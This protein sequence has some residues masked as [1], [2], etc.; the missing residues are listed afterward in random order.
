[1]AENGGVIGIHFCSRLVLG[2][3]GIQSEIEDV[4]KQIEAVTQIGGIEVVGLG[5]DYMLNFE[6]RDEDYLRNTNQLDISWTKGLEDTSEIYNIVEAL[7]KAGFSESDID[8]IT[9]G[10]MKRLIGDVLPG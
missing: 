1:M 4:V 7:K 8:K 10:N 6:G 5:P 9:S 3:N 2:V